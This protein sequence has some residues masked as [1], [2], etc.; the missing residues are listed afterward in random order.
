MVYGDFCVF[1][2]DKNTFQRTTTLALRVTNS[3]GGWCTFGDMERMSAEI[4]EKHRQIVCGLFQ[5]F[6]WSQALKDVLVECLGEHLDVLHVTHMLE[7]AEGYFEV[8]CVPEQPSAQYNLTLQLHNEHEKTDDTKN[9]MHYN[10]VSLHSLLQN[11]FHQWV[12]GMVQG[13]VRI[14]IRELGEIHQLTF[15]TY[16]GQD[17]GLL[18]SENTDI[19]KSLETIVAEH[20]SR[21]KDPSHDMSHVRRVMHNADAIFKEMQTQHKILPLCS[22][23][24]CLLSGYY[25][26]EHVVVPTLSADAIMLIRRVC[27]LLAAALHDVSDHKFKETQMNLSD[28]FA[29]LHLNRLVR[30]HVRD[31]ITPHSFSAELAGVT[32]RCTEAEI[33]RDADRLDAL[34]HIG[35]ARA[36]S[37]GARRGDP[38]MDVARP[39][40]ECVTAE[41]YKASGGTTVNHFYEKLFTLEG[42]MVT[43]PG[44]RMA[45]ERTAYMRE[46]MSKFEQDFRAELSVFGGIRTQIRE[47]SRWEAPH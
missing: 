28:V 33:L 12:L 44:K 39:P 17:T 27:L 45:A 47:L 37:F 11:I 40:R 31:I 32:C 5:H 4:V 10:R 9:A 36:F 8:F 43:A 30:E 3:G 35:I 34:G 7:R 42:R 26:S 29:M 14:Y 19:A 1:V 20:M 38:M 25:R 13:Q 46:F 22:S 23:A 6:S 24:W 2:L 15:V 16:R 21:Y 18:L 41:Q